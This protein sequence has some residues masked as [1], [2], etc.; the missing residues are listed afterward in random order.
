MG[1]GDVGQ[2]VFDGEHGSHHA[3]FQLSIKESFNGKM[4]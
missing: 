2:W 4:P 1:V 3:T